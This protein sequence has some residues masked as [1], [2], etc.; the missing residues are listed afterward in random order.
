MSK[1]QVLEPPKEVAPLKSQLKRYHPCE[2]WAFVVAKDGKQQLPFESVAAALKQVPPYLASEFRQD[3]L[4]W[5]DES[6]FDYSQ[7][8]RLTVTLGR[9]PLNAEGFVDFARGKHKKIGQH[10]EPYFLEF[11][12]NI[13]DDMQIVLDRLPLIFD[14]LH[15]RYDQKKPDYVG[16]YLSYSAC[17]RS[18][19]VETLNRM[20]GAPKAR[21]LIT[22]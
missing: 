7:P 9:G 17:E 22:V 11:A 3:R 2:L 6:E 18:I 10:T 1:I 19:E 14:R 21:G 15:K 13:D 8:V 16:I 12:K 20:L 5:L 4:S